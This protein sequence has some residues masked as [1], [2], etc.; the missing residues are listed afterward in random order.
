ML[1]LK[2]AAAVI[3]KLGPFLDDGDGK[4]PETGL[5]IAQGDIQISKNGGAFAQTSAAAPTTTH[6][7]DGW[8]PIP[9]T[10]TDTGTAGTLTVQVY[11]VGALPVWIDCMVL[12]AA[13]YDALFGGAGGAIPATV[14]GYA[15][16]QDPASL[17][18]TPIATIAKID[19]L[20]E[21]IP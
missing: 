1:L 19:T 12:P 11:L 16:G 15:A 18:A 14:E 21:V 9:L 4:T 17:L 2:Q 13:I 6:D 3:L 10:Q 20:L 8:Y 7:A 5:T